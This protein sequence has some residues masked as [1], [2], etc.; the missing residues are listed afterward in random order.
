MNNALVA[1]CGAL[2]LAST[3]TLSAQTPPPTPAQPVWPNATA[4]AQPEHKPA[5]GTMTMA[6]CLKVSDSTVAAAPAGARYVLA[7]AAMERPL[8]GGPMG[9]PTSGAPA[10]GAP[11]AAAPPAHPMAT[12]YMVVAGSGVDLTAHVN[13]QV[14]ITGT[15]AGAHAGMPGMMPGGKPMAKPGDTPMA[16]PDMPATRP[17]DVP[18]PNPMGMDHKSADKGWSTLTAASITMI[19]A[20]CTATQ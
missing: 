9:T 15:V 3:M 1:A 4:P 18:K 19:S 14:R 5:P 20:T 11:G 2:A 7:N 12:Q 16:K 8:F 10:P 17:G 13:H 6:G